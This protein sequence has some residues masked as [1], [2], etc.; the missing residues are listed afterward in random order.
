MIPISFLLTWDICC[1]FPRIDSTTNTGTTR[2]AI[3]W[4]KMID[5]DPFLASQ[6]SMFWRMASV[7]DA[8]VASLEALKARKLTA[9][10]PEGMVQKAFLYRSKR[11]L[12]PQYGD[13]TLEYWKKFAANDPE[14]AARS[15][16]YWIENPEA[17]MYW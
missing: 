14:V 9:L 12:N 3:L 10:N 13:L 16:M 1:S 4:K 8:K 11:S 15:A 5:A 7:D 17:N 2:A 6:A